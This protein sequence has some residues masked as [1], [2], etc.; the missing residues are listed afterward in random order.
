MTLKQRAF[1]SKWGIE[2]K[3]TYGDNPCIHIKNSHLV[4]VR[5]DR[6]AILNGEYVEIHGEFEYSTTMYL[7]EP[8][9]T[10]YQVIKVDGNTLKEIPTDLYSAAKALCKER[11]VPYPRV[12]QTAATASQRST[13][14]RQ[15]TKN[16]SFA[17]SS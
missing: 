5:N 7:S 1:F 17:F 8:P 16:C 9:R 4:D 10:L 6:K 14:Q 13:Y 2:V 15:T 3:F 12:C 11:P